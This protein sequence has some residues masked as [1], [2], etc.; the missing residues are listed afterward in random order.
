[1]IFA[2]ALEAESS[3][4]DN[5]LFQNGVLTSHLPCWKLINMLPKESHYIT[6]YL[7]KQLLKCKIL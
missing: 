7:P 1:M 6:H 5:I 3:S 2:G 4:F